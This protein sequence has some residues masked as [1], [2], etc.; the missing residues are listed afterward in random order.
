[1][2]SQPDIPD[3]AIQALPQKI[4]EIRGQR[5]MLDADLAELFGVP[6]KRFNEQIKRNQGRFPADFMFVLTFEE[7]MP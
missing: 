7:I 6:T 3:S 2:I 1:M 4:L 5:V